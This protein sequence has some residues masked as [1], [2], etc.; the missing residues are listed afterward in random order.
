MSFRSMV[1]AFGDGTR[2][3]GRS[4][5]DLGEVASEV[6]FRAVEKTSEAYWNARGGPWCAQYHRVA[7]LTAIGFFEGEPHRE[8][9]MDPF[10]ALEYFRQLPDRY[11]NDAT[12]RRSCLIVYKDNWYCVEPFADDA[13]H[14][15]DVMRDEVARDLGLERGKK[16]IAGGNGA[17]TA[18]AI[19]RG[20]SA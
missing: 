19:N 7:P 12:L 3:G 15:V 14:A 5:P 20:G 4:L 13:D 2:E 17:G 10:D 6:G 16:Q 8:H 9:F 18:G 1:S 11:R